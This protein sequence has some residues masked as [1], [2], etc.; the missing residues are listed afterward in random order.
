MDYRRDGDLACQDVE[1]MPALRTTECLARTLG[2]V[3][4]EISR[5]STKATTSF[6]YEDHLDCRPS[7]DG[8]R[9]AAL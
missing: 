8:F 4:H 9:I 6:G 2:L 7:C 1:C 3:E 5:P